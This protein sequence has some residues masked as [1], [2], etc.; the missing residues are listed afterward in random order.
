MTRTGL[1]IALGLFAAIA[2]IFGVW[3]EL[4][5]KL[6][7]LFYNPETRN[8]PTSSLPWAEFARNGAMWISWAFVAPSLLALIAKLI[9]P[10]RPL[11]VKGR[12]MAFLVITIVLSAGVL[13]N[14]TFKSLWG[15]PRPVM[16]T[17]LGGPW[18]FKAW[19]DP[20][21]QCPKNC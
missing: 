17:E 19:W 15:R 18:Q 2:I 7:A 6:A 4:D 1:H 9:W 5:L 12:T 3:P 20:T 10:N 13:T 14:L 21:G 11:L 16:V 8:F